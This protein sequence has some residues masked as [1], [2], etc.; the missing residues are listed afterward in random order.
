MKFCVLRKYEKMHELQAAQ[1]S[2]GRQTEWIHSARKN[3]TA[4]RRCWGIHAYAIWVNESRQRKRERENCISRET[5]SSWGRLWAAAAAEE[6][7]TKKHW[8]EKKEKGAKSEIYDD[9]SSTAF[10]MIISQS[11]YEKR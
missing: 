5:A 2:S 3:Y 11:A 10:D 1:D 7:T 6:K 9:N 4:A 8:M